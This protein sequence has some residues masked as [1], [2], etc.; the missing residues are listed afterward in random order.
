[1]IFDLW[2]GNGGPHAAPGVLSETAQA[3][4]EMG[5]RALW[6]SDHLLPPRDQAR[7]ARTFEPLTLLAHLAGLT[8]RIRLGTPLTTNTSGATYLRRFPGT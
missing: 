6:A 3:A 2:L 7:F 5:F 1:M 4:D 8:R